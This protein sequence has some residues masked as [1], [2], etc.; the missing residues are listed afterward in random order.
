MAAS[1]MLACADSHG[2]TTARAT[3]PLLYEQMIL[4]PETRFQSRCRCAVCVLR[5]AEGS[6]LNRRLVFATISASLLAFSQWQCGGGTSAPRGQAGQGG[7]SETG[8]DAGQGG[9]PGT[10]GGGNGGTGGTSIVVPERDSGPPKVDAAEMCV[11]AAACAIG[12]GNSKI[13]TGLCEVCDDG[14]IQAG[15]G[16]SPDCKTIEKD[17]TCLLPGSPCAYLVKCGDGVIGGKE[18]C[19]DG[20]MK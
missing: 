3:A 4:W 6:T 7:S 15:D 20:N 18:T 17:W 19:D 12:C 11:D 10:S 13:D 16:C 1:S 2:P 5:R 8:I 9:E 14:N